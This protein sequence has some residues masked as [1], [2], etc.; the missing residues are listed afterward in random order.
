MCESQTA[1]PPTANETE[2][3]STV[4]CLHSGQRGGKKPQEKR[5]R[6]CATQP[7]K[8]RVTRRASRRCLAVLSRKTN[9]RNSKSCHEIGPA[10]DSRALTDLREGDLR[11]RGFSGRYATTEEAS[12]MASKRSSNDNN[13]PLTLPALHDSDQINGKEDV[14]IVASHDM[15][16]W[17]F[18]ILISYVAPPANSQN[19]TTQSSQ[20]NHRTCKS[21]DS[22][23]STFSADQQPFVRRYRSKKHCEGL[24]GFFGACALAV[25]NPCSYCAAPTH[26]SAPLP[27]DSVIAYSCRQVNVPMFVSWMTLEKQKSGFSFPINKKKTL[28]VLALMLRCR[29][30]Q[31]RVYLKKLTR[32]YWVIAAR[33]HQRISPVTSCWC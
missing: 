31:G 16:A 6:E 33:A 9:G 19:H 14:P 2:T 7:A 12:V 21:S 27:P 29:V 30:L 26:N 8:K 28:V 3:C 20:N 13:S 18:A 5:T 10:A 17:C 32:V 23:S 24:S 15:C 22:S 1:L 4:E 25:T 11:V